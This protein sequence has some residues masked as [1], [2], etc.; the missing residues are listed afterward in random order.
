MTDSGRG[1]PEEFRSRVFEKFFR[2]EHYRPG[3]EREPRGAGIG[4]Y[5]C[6]EIVGLHGGT[7]RCE[8]FC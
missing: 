4:L 5:L 8:A 6:K 2:V 3:G 7:I 1:V